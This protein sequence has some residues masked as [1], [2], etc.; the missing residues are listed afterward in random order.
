VRGRRA[1]AFKIELG[2]RTVV[3][4]LCDAAS[5]AAASRVAAV[6]QGH[7]LDASS[8]SV[9][10]LVELAPYPS[11]ATA[12]EQPRWWSL[13]ENLLPILSDLCRTSR[14]FALAT[15]T[16]AEGGPRPAG[17]QMVFTDDRAW[18]SLSGGCV[19]ADL[20]CHARAALADRRSRQ[21]VYGRG[22]PW[23]DIR[24]AC[25]ARLEVL[26]EPVSPDDPILV[27]LLGL[28]SRREV[29]RYVSD[30]RKRL[31]RPAEE[32]IPGHWPVDVLHAPSQR[33]LVV[34]QDPFAYAIA[35]AGRHMDW[36]VR[37][38][39]LLWDPRTSG[40]GSLTLGPPSLSRPTTRSRTMRIYA[41]RS[42][43][44]RAMSEFLDR[45]A[46]CPSGSRG[47]GTPGSRKPR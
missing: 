46:A 10:P 31:C 17:T 47:S 32:D 1:R 38:S 6:G 5:R 28:A 42:G 25:G 3:R 24:L 37:R 34:G 11:V 12:L 33:L 43:R 14:P 16:A 9:A 44:K 20:A 19:E 22:S 21:V 35:V 7:D 8:S 27:E 30:G 40:A 13:D 15:V 18:G 45:A 41:S 4:A 2:R 29:V 36:E 23:L 26:V 39:R